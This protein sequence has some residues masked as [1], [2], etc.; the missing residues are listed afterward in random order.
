MLKTTIQKLL[1]HKI[2]T[3]QSLMVI[4]ILTIEILATYALAHR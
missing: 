2:I 3:P 4:E 1:E